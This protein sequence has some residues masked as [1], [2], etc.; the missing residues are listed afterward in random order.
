MDNAG[1]DMVRNLAS[2]GSAEDSLVLD[3]SC[4]ADESGIS[5]DTKGRRNCCLG[6]PLAAIAAYLD[7]D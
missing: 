1:A 4:T 6:G 2:T 5:L 3:T 7:I